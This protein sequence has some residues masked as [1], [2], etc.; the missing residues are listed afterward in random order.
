MVTRRWMSRFGG[1]AGPGT[2][3]A[4][5]RTAALGLVALV[6]LTGCGGGGGSSS[7]TT[8]AT[9]STTLSQAQLDKAKAQR[10]VFSAADLP[11]YTMDPAEAADDT[12]VLEPDA[13]A[14]ANNNAVLAQLGEETD[15]RG[16]T[17]AD[18]SKGDAISVGSAATFA[19]TDDQARAV[20]TDLGAASFPACFS[21]SLADALRKEPTL[22]NVT[23]TST[24]LPPIT[25]GEQSI[26]FRSVAR[27]RSS[28]T[29]LT[30]NADFTFIRVG[31]AVAA[32]YDSSIGTVF[33]ADERARLAAALAGRMTAS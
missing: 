23:V 6:L 26:A 20:F 11:G 12:A 21:R 28:G 1:S 31:R 8:V 27:F 29:A 14:C 32:F 5:N 24:R 22:T 30:L 13:A 3:R 16:A 25:A 2:G 17:S 10:I 19:D 33:P 18:Y 7:P 15:L 9:T 4:R